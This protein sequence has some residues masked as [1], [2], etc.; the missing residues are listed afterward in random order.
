LAA[1]LTQRSVD[2]AKADPLKRREIPDGA[3]PGFYLV[4]QPS[5]AKSWAVRYR[6]AGTPRKLT[7]GPYPRLS[8]GDARGAARSALRAASEGR[9][10][11]AERA[12][13]K[14]EATAGRFTFGAVA[15]EYVKR[16][17]KAHHRTWG[18]AERLLTR[19]DLATWKD[20][21]IRAVTRRDVLDVLDAIIERGAAVQA[22]RLLTRLKPFFAWCV[23]RGIL[24]VSPVATLR[25]PSPETSRDRVLADDELA[26]I[27]RAADEIGYPFGRAIQLLIL[28]GQRRSE[29][30]E[31]EWP[32]FDVVG[33]M[34]TLPKERSKTGVAHVVSLSE[35]VLNLLG[36]LPRI[37]APPRLLFTTNGVTPFSGVSKAFDRLGK[38]AARHRGAPLAHWRPHD[39]RRTFASGCARL[40]V[41]VHV[42]EKALN[43]TSG[44]FGGIVGVYQR[45][46]YL[47][48]RR[49][50]LEAWAAHVMGLVNGQA[51]SNVVELRG[52]A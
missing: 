42:V 35:P 33:R 5:G 41:P 52:R 38:L 2:Q 45:H 43:H 3:L 19:A 1:T 37:G 24:E 29:V 30:L 47:E 4:L 25:P 23:E 9:D 21:D 51:A 10:P 36:D 6:F 12:N 7:V 8:L 11:A 46:D 14:R 22:N 32:E 44:T 40:G 48:E 27:W 31:A 50:A 16:H 15:E 17:A 49:H 18:E 13:K 26:A 39:L 28:T 20:R 34:W